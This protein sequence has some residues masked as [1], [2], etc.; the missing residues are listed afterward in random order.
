[1]VLYIKNATFI[2]CEN[3]EFKKTNIKVEQGLNG[4]IKFIDSI[5]DVKN[6]IDNNI[7]IIDAKEKLVTK[8][9]GC[10]HHHIYSALARGMPA[11]IKT[12][13][14]F[15][16]IL[17]YVW[18]NLDKNLD[19][20]MIKASALCSALFCAR[21]GVT[22]VIDHHSSPFSIDNSLFLI[23]EAFEAIGISSLLCYEL[24]DRDGKTARDKGLVET[25]NYLKAGN[26][27]H[28]GLHASFTVQDSLLK[29][30]VT[31]AKKYNTGIHVHVAEDIADQNK[32]LKNYNKRVIQRFKDSG[33]L[34]FSKTILSHCI[35]LNDVEKDIL[36]NSKAWI[37]EN[38]E[39][40]LNNNVGITD[41]LKHGSN[42]MLGTDGMHC[43]M[44]RSAKAVFFVGQETEKISYPEIYARFR[45]IHKF[46][47]QNK[48]KGDGDNNLVIL[49]YNTPTEINQDNFFGH[50]VFGIE[51]SHVESVISS[52][53]L[54]IKNKKL[55]TY[56][57]QDILAF[58][59]EMAHKLWKKLK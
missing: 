45:N 46:L 47:G 51:S 38:I 36:K 15:L 20:D 27:G 28:V 48:Y 37:V 6:R 33:M 2:D 8:S 29:K 5:P 30:A 50:F 32:C 40:N 39:S 21:N 23:K 10:G 57:E 16:E 13:E 56:N 12:P 52:G 35:H 3:L 26:Q 31:L 24:S 53:K 22:F 59:K 9:F 7:K 4:K 1:M 58:S 44:L 25:E 19:S 41:Y 11:P 43:D 18:W 54:I 17:K 34:D 49:D 42:I 14:N 55:L